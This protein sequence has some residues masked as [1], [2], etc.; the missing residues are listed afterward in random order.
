L[1]A[2]YSCTNLVP[3]TGHV[4][5]LRGLPAFTTSTLNLDSYGLIDQLVS[6]LIANERTKVVLA[7]G[8]EAVV[9]FAKR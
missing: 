4:T 9:H 8:A 1:P 3:H 6:D 5:A 2:L 7:L